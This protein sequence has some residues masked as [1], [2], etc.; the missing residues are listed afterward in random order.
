MKKAKPEEDDG[1]HEEEV[2]QATMKVEVAGDCHVEG[3]VLGQ[4][5]W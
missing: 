5:S 4:A 3:V 1:W 2:V